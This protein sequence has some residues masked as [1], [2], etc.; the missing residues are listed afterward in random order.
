[1]VDKHGLQNSDDIFQK[2]ATLVNVQLAAEGSESLPFVPFSNFNSTKY[3]DK[4]LLYGPS[5]C[6][7]SRA[8]FE[9]VKENLDNFKKIYF[10]NPRNAI[11]NESGRIKLLDLI[12]KLEEDDGVVW[13]NFPDDLVKRDLD[14][15]RSV[16]E[17][18]GSRNVKRFLVA[19]KPKYLE[20]YRDLL[21][22][23]IPE[24]YTCEVSFDKEQIKSIIKTYG[25]E[26]A[27]FSQTYRKYI[28]KDID[29]ISRILWQKEP[30]PLT[31]LDYY[32]ELTNKIEQIQ[33]TG[34]RQNDLSIDPLS[35]AEK[36][37]RS[38]HYY[39]HQF[40]LISSM[41]ERQPDAEFLCT[42]KLCYESGLNT[43]SY[44]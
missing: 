3:S 34:I 27:Q 36:L 33:E 32:K 35:E 29:K 10:I 7:K 42:L 20:I 19:I 14:N 39:E 23:G 26:I 18:V 24:F 9:L 22:N 17:I 16:L 38:T 13:D 1:M 28:E 8:M 11:G 37:L 40:A 6:S 41:Q 15:A 31:I 44:D 30:A 21:H 4:L 2:I 25:T 12:G 5:G 43:I